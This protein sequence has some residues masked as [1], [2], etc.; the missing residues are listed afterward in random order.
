MNGY[1]VYK[2]FALTAKNR[3]RSRDSVTPVCSSS[4]VLFVDVSSKMCKT[5]HVLR[6]SIVYCH[7][8]SNSCSFPIKLSIPSALTK[9]R[10]GRNKERRKDVYTH[11]TTITR[12]AATAIIPTQ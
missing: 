12:P 9:N 3:G 11:H 5:I 6:R 10:E 2:R 7:R 8:V 4:C 1:A